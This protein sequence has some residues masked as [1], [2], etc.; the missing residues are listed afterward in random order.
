[1]L[2]EVDQRIFLSPVEND[3]G[4]IMDNLIG[5][6]E[7]EI[8]NG[9]PIRRITRHMLGLFSGINGARTWRRRLSSPQYIDNEGIHGLRETLDKLLPQRNKLFMG[10]TYLSDY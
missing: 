7:R 9:V 2:K 5:Y 8:E 4:L 6:V 3:I 1:M 10:I